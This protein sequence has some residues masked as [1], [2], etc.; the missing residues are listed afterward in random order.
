MADE[1]IVRTILT[2]SQIVRCQ[3]RYEFAYGWL[4]RAVSASISASSYFI[5]ATPRSGSTLLCGLLRSTGIAGRPESYFRVP[6]EQMWADRWQLSQDSEGRPDYH[7]YARAAV[8]EGSTGNGVFGARI[9]WGTMD[10]VVT[11]LG[12]ARPDAAG[13]DL[14]LLT[15]AFGP[16]RFVHL[17]REDTVAQAVSWSRAE[18]TNYWHPPASFA[19]EREPRFD[20]EQIN[21]FVE[22]I[23][24]HNTAWRHWFAANDV[25]PHP[26]RYE[27]M[28]ADV[29]G[30]TR[31]ILDFLGL[32]L[33]R[34]RTIA[35]RDQRQADEMNDEW[36]A[37]YRA[38]RP[39]RTRA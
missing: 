12:A 5:C 22:T 29:G 23:D 30:V 11:E 36:I 32:E 14:N 19:P 26:V 9:M 28:V 39:G 37:R 17:W 2:Q 25:R 35:A 18:Q 10:R 13:A 16:T 7:E 4:A 21:A 1:R 38:H 27:E 31:G 24:E 3:D 15:R 34:D 6:D 20:F 33:A 8:G